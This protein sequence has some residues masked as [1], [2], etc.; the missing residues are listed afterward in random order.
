MQKQPI[1]F[2]DSGVGGLTLLKEALKRLPN[3][4]MVFIGDQARLHMVKSR[5]KPCANLRGR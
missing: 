2:M 4:D 5:R 1:G 3:E